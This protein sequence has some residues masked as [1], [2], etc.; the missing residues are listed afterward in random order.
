MIKDGS[1]SFLSALVKRLLDV[2]KRPLFT[3]RPPHKCDKQT[4]CQAPNLSY[5]WD[6][7]IN[8]QSDNKRE[9]KKKLFQN[10]VFP[11]IFLFFMELLLQ[12]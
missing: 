12:T 1:E 6:P 10:N 3:S 9:G 5:Q 11:K 2:N 8:F 4:S 7:D